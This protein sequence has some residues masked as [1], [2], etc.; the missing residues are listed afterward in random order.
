MYEYY[1]DVVRVVD[2]DTIALNINLGFHV[3]IEEKCR[4]IYWYGDSYDAPESRKYPG[5]SEE[6][7]IEGK[8]ATEAAR[9]LLPVGRRVLVRTKKDK[10]GKYGRFLAAIKFLD[11]PEAGADFADLMTAAG[12]VK[13][14]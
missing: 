9:Q 1:A 10:Q 11:G 6:E 3:N 12:Y 8:K 5:V 13:E 4:I 7:V 2:G 14:D